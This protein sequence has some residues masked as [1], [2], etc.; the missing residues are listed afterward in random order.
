MA[1]E[2]AK[3]AP[4]TKKDERLTRALATAALGLSLAALVLAGYS[5]YAQRRAEEELRDVGRELSR[6]LRARDP[7]GAPPLGLDPDDT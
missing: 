2:R 6:A 1:A 7:L 5:L 4:R 3:S